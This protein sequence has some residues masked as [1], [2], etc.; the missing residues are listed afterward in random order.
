MNFLFSNGIHNKAPIN[1]LKLMNI[2]AVRKKETNIKMIFFRYLDLGARKQSSKI[3][4]C[5]YF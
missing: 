4:L 2:G 3:E 1:K 5:R